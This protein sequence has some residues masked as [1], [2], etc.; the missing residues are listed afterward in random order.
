MPTKTS[1]GPNEVVR[2]EVLRLAPPLQ[3]RPH[4]RHTDHRYH[5]PDNRQPAMSNERP[6]PRGCQRSRRSSLAM[7]NGICHL[8]GC[9]SREVLIYQTRTACPAACRRDITSCAVLCMLADA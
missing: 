9:L 8:L 5:Q 7:P 1:V 2:L 3:H 6:E 4:S